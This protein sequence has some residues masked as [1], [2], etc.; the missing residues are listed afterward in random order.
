MQ[1]YS[2]YNTGN[3]CYSYD[4]IYFYLI[5]SVCIFTIKWFSLQYLILYFVIRHI[6]VLH[7]LFIYLYLLFYSCSVTKYTR[8]DA[9]SN[10]CKP[11][12]GLRELIGKQEHIHVVYL[13]CLGLNKYYTTKVAYYFNIQKVMQSYNYISGL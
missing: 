6:L 9:I 5:K 8:G 7:S 13:Y 12:Q 11:L 2:V 1:Y 10:F 4:L 3:V